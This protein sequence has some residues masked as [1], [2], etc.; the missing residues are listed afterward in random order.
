MAIFKCKMCGGALNVEVGATV[1]ECEFCGTK[2]TVPRLDSERKASLYDRA[3][4]FRRNNEYDKA[5]GIYEIIL[6]EDKTDAEA[7]WSALLCRYGVEY[8]EDPDSKKMI[9]TVNRT[10]FTSILNDE[11]YQ[12]ALK[13]A[14]G[15]Q[16]DI[17]KEQAKEIDRIQ[18]GILDISSKEEPFDVFICYKESDS[19]G[20]RTVDSV[21]AQ[22]IYNNL[23]NE[24]LKVFFARI[25]LEDKL[26]IAYEPYIFAALNSAKVMIVVGTKK[27]HFESVWVKNEWSRYLALINSGKKKTLIPAYKGM[28]AYDLPQ[29][30][31]HLQAQDVNKIG[32]MQD[33]IHGVKKL[34]KKTE[35][36]VAT[37]TVVVEKNDN[38]AP[39]L[40]RTY[41]FL[42]DKDFV[43]A[44]KYVEKILDIN[45][46]Y[47]E[48][49]FI[50]VLVELGVTN[51]EELV[52]NARDELSSN[53]NYQRALRFADEKFKAKLIGY[54]AGIVKKA[55]E[56][57][58]EQ[59]Y[60]LAVAKLSERL[61]LEAI[62]IFESISDYKDSSNQIKRCYELIEL[63]K[64]ENIYCTAVTRI[65]NRVVDDVVL[66][67]SIQDLQSISGYKDADEK[68]CELQARLEKYYY[69]KKI[70]EEQARIRAEEERLRKL[71][72]EE[73]RKI[74]IEKTKQ[75]VKK[76][77][78][79]GVPSILALTLVLVLTFTVFVPIGKYSKAEKL[80]NNG[81][82]IRAIKIY[83]DLGDYKQS[84]QIV[85]TLN[86]VKT[87][88]KGSYEKGIKDILELGIPV[89]ISYDFNGGDLTSG[90]ATGENAVELYSVQ[91]SS[92][93]YT[94]NDISEF[95]GLKSPKRSGYSLKGWSFVSSSVAM[96]KTINNF[97]V[98]LIAKWETVSYKIT[99][100]L[101]GGADYITNPTE[102]SVE[103]AFTLNNPVREGYT[104]IGWTG[105]GLNGLTKDVTVSIGSF[106]ERE[107]TAHWD[108][109]TNVI[110]F[111]ANGGVGVMQNQTA[112]TDQVI[113]LNLVTYTCDGY[114]FVGWAS[115][116]NG[117]VEFVNGQIYSMGASAE[118][119]L[120]AV[121]KKEVQYTVRYY[122]QNLDN[123]NYT[124]DLTRRQDTYGIAGETI[125][126]ASNSVEHFTFNEQLSNKTGT[127]SVGGN[128]VF[129]LYYTRNSYKVTTNVNNSVAGVAFGGSTNKYGKEITVTA[130]TNSG[131]KFIGWHKNGELVCSTQ[132]YTFVPNGNI[133]L[134][135]MFEVRTDVPYKV[136]Y[137]M[138]NIDNNN[139]SQDI[140]RTQ[141]LFGTFNTAVMVTPSEIEHFTF[142]ESLSS[143]SGIISA[144]GSLVLRLSY[145]RKSYT[146]TTTVNN[147]NAG[148]SSGGGTCR[149]GKEITVTATANINLGYKF[150][151]W[152]ENGELV[153]STQEYTFTP[154]KN[155]TLTA[156]FEIAP[157]LANFIFT[158]TA[159]TCDIT[160]VKDKTVTEIEI[161]DFVTGIGYEAFSG[162]S[163]LTSVTIPDSVT[164][165]G[166]WAFFGCSS[167]T[168]II[169]GNNV[170]AVHD[171]AFPTQLYNIKD[172]L[173]YVGNESNKYLWLVGVENESITTAIIDSN[174]KVI[175]MNAFYY[176]RSLTSVTIPDSI[177]NIGI[178]AFGNCSSLTS[179][180]IP[181]SVTKIS[182]YAFD[183]CTSLESIIIPNSVTSIGEFA[184]S[185]CDSLKTIYC[186]AE[187]KLP[188]WNNNWKNGCS[189]D[190]VWGYKD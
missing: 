150:I 32:F 43:S 176:C 187:S 170:M 72:E 132:E 120:Y 74:K 119:H 51:V 56:R 48:A 168:S 103:D 147:S 50:K 113:T 118:Y 61:Y 53:A 137:Y 40:R 42:E 35:K 183:G 1:L 14:D 92:K 62:K 154:N 69:D 109:N 84:E 159:T 11:D 37:E 173:I 181:D 16:R 9:P 82:Y 166:A 189:A 185:N 114:V 116:P 131:Y 5:A 177:T 104:F 87:I 76:T 108:A 21:L 52:D 145:T 175:C 71:R 29:E 156:N 126:F 141:N 121:W 129:T 146:V 130:N 8:V 66:K 22:D 133:T 140:S 2:Q 88:E 98:R 91:S 161:P 95:D 89:T 110:I 34:V 127:L 81:D 142:N 65:T 44:D 96:D 55:E 41:L 25:T 111:N 122:L 115:T 179:V 160:G 36:V 136:E 144:D 19:N 105:T 163:S 139:Y 20:R 100:D 75:K 68:V 18:Q 45:P 63:A 33:L 67:Q 47:A 86:I 31:L 54:N 184:F 165:I 90:F 30:F 101:Q 24:G 107:Y 28:D 79:I 190:I 60:Q 171:L 73:L 12:T 149:Y 58:K 77:A 186:E 135:A 27:E 106:G 23:K 38:V 128:N 97:T 59:I 155:L 112:K 13:Y 57:R 158:Y 85:N 124:E 64:K 123:D 188:T 151:G 3:N 70:A 26:G 78:R 138:Q 162:C 143:T 99:Y 164:E 180:T 117:A 134:V 46:E 39:L 148:T 6:N 80:V 178:Y 93:T 17:Y 102:Y 94:Y 83:E 182:Y 172:G 167:L 125:N 7:Y 10:Q 169:G 153:C 15:Y 49:Y 157:E 174:C 152:Y 4:H